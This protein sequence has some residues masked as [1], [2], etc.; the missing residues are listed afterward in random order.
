MRVFFTIHKEKKLPRSFIRKKS[1]HRQNYI[2]TSSVTLNPKIADKV[3]IAD[4][5]DCDTESDSQHEVD[6]KNDSQSLEITVEYGNSL[7]VT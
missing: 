6:C 2:Q 4:T 5:S 7:C 3:L 1:L